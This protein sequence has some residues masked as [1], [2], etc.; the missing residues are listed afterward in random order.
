VR[1][2]GEG[3]RED[4]PEIAGVADTAAEQV[5]KAS[6]YMREHDAREVMEAAQDVARRQPLAVVA[7][8]LAL[9]LVVGRFLRSTGGAASRSSFRGYGDAGR[10]TAGYGGTGSGAARSSAAAEYTGSG[11]GNG[12]STSGAGTPGRSATTGRSGAGND[13]AGS[14]NPSVAGSGF[15][16]EARGRAGGTKSSRA[17]S[18]GTAGTRPGTSGTGGTTRVDVSSVTDKGG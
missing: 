1:D 13:D 17:T 9:G 12:G 2:A 14:G 15:S 18:T 4:R 3:V 5:E 8:G 16:G 7:G 6:R 11:Y 10:S